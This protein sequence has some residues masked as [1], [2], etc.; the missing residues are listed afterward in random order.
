MMP[1]LGPIEPARHRRQDRRRLRSIRRITSPASIICIGPILAR[2]VVFG[3]RRALAQYREPRRYREDLA[4]LLCDDSLA[5]PAAAGGAN[6]PRAIRTCQTRRRSQGS[7]AGPNPAISYFIA[8]R[9]TFH[10][11]SAE[12]TRRFVAIGRAAAWRAVGLPRRARRRRRMHATFVATLGSA[13]HPGARPKRVAEAQRA[14]P[15]PRT[16]QQRF[17]SC[18]ASASSFSAATGGSPRRRSSRNSWAFSRNISCAPTAPAS[19]Q[20]GGEQFRVTDTRGR[21]A[22]K[23]S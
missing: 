2:A 17:R 6:S 16:V 1:V 7:D 4:G 8:N 11:V 13:G 19:A 21:T 14:G 3:H 20:Y 15:L 10:E 9:P 18:P 23:P 22:R 12:M 5:V